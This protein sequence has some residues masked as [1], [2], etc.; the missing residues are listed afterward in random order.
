MKKE[1]SSNRDAYESIKHELTD[2][3]PYGQFLAFDNGVLIADA[4]S[5]DELTAKL[6]QLGKDRPDIFVVQAGIEYP[7]EVFILL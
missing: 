7:D 2:R 1:P 6:V 5:F 4:S 3:Y